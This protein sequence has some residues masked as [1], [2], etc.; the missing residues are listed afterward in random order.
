MSPS[1]SHRPFPHLLGIPFE[2]RNKIYRLSF[3]ATTLNKIDPGRGSARW[4]WKSK[5]GLEL[6]CK[7]L[8]RECIQIW[9]ELVRVFVD[10][11]DLPMKSPPHAGLSLCRRCCRHL[12]GTAQPLAIPSRLADQLRHIEIINGSILDDMHQL[13]V[14]W[15]P[16]AREVIIQK[17]VQVGRALSRDQVVSFAVRGFD[18]IVYASQNTVE[19]KATRL[20]IKGPDNHLANVGRP[21][22]LHSSCANL[23]QEALVDSMTGELLEWWGWERSVTGEVIGLEKLA[24]PA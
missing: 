14:S 7:K 9:T 23:E 5:P 8:R 15:F 24:L 13:D 22:R 18:S 2:V 6:V 11:E 19:L 16:G 1:T 20:L 4:R 12:N 3:E 10:I 21:S 17:P